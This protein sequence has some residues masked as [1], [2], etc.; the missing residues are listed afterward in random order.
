MAYR[1][2]AR[3]KSRLVGVHSDLI[4]VAMRAIQLTSV[5]F[6]ISEG[7]R[8]IERQRLLFEQGA[9]KLM[10]S[11]HLSG[12]AIDVYAYVGGEARW[13]WPLYYK[14]AEAFKQAAKEERVPIRW[15]G[16]WDMD[17]ETEDESFP[18]GPHFELPRFAYPA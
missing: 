4:R 12:H 15:G 16:D 18:D 14:I 13:D 3:S 1:L 2:S 9:T 17:G 7:V 8:S 10:K 11:R 6:G 5:D